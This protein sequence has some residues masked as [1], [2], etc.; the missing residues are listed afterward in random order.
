[1]NSRVSERVTL[2][3]ALLRHRPLR[4]TQ[5]HASISQRRCSSTNVKL[6]TDRASM[7]RTIGWGIW[8]ASGLMREIQANH[9]R[10]WSSIAGDIAS[11][12]TVHLDK[13]Q[14]IKSSVFQNHR[15]SFG[16]SRMSDWWWVVAPLHCVYTNLSKPC[17][18]SNPQGVLSFRSARKTPK[19]NCR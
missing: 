3:V 19:Y 12:V 2:I 1:M 13:R 14:A 17:A 4:L 15:V 5:T 9:S 16:K 10:F 8:A 7:C 18:L 6:W 11:N